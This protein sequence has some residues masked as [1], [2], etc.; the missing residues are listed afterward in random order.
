M[1][2]QKINLRK[3]FD[4]CNELLGNK[5]FCKKLYILP[6]MRYWI[7]EVNETVITAAIELEDKPYHIK[8]IKFNPDIDETEMTESLQKFMCRAMTLGDNWKTYKNHLNKFKNYK[9]INKLSTSKL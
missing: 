4:E 1:K 6:S 7:D 9:K 5:L 8:S 3:I 2:D